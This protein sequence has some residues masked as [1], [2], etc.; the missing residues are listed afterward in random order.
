MRVIPLKA[1]PNQRLTVVLND[2]NCTIR[3][4]QR[5]DY[6]Y[7]DL[8]VDGMEIRRGAICLSEINIPAYESPYFNGVLFFV[9]MNQRD[10]IPVY[11]EL[12]TRYILCYEV[13]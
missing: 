11:S 4:Y 12:N 6:L 13:E 10:G 8:T 9:D 3:I 2:Q 5:G 7:M 1:I